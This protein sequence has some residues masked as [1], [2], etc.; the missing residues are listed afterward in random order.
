MNISWNSGKKPQ[1]LSSGKSPATNNRLC[2]NNRKT[3][4]WNFA[5]VLGGIGFNFRSHIGLIISSN[6][7]NYLLYKKPNGIWIYCGI[8][9]TIKFILYAAPQGCERENNNSIYIWSVNSY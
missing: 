9:S 2:S 5:F 7:R 3:S 8:Y 6:V 1:S 4:D